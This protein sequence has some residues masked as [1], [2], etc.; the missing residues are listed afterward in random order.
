MYKRQTSKGVE[1]IAEWPL[2]DSLSLTGNYTYNDTEDAEGEDRI[3]RPEH[4]AN[5][6]LA[7]VGM[8]GRLSL[9]LN[10]RLS[11][12][13][14]DTIGEDTDDYEVVD[15]NASFEVIEGLDIFGRVENLFDEDYQEIPTYNTSGAA[16]YAGVRYSF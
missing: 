7:W 10:A 4:L 2:L 3:Y 5:L 1:L 15:I 6:G 11:H 8:D 9:G 14:V 13:A 16:A 12:G